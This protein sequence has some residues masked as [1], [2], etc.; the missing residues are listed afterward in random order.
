MVLE[1]TVHHHQLFY[2]TQNQLTPPVTGII[3]DTITREHLDDGLLS[4][5]KYFINYSFYKFGL[6]VSKYQGRTILFGLGPQQ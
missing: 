4:C 2:R 5:I 3:F 1:V 6:E